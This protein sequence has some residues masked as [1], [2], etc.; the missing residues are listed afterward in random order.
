MYFKDEEHKEQTFAILNAFGKESVDQDLQYGMLAYIVGAT[1]KGN[2]L[3]KF[4][5]EYGEIDIDN[6]YEYMKVFSN[7]EKSM[8][9][10]AFQCYNNAIDDIKL[11]D[12][13]WSLDAKNTRVIKQA[14]N[15]LY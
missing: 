10:F 15:I 13:M 3:L 7:T 9:R 2:H 12:V 5:N 11:S 6:F 8:I 4:I 14:I 1:Y